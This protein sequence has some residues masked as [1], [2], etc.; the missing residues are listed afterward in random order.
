MCQPDAAVD[1]AKAQRAVFNL[2]EHDGASAAVA[3]AAT[4][5]GAG[6]PKVFAQ[7][8]QRRAIGWYIAEIDHFAPAQKADGFDKML[9]G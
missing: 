6:Q 2:A 7:Q 4:F 3:F 8:V 9:N 1:G 5:F